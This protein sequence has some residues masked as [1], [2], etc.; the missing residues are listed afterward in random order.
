MDE[1]KIFIISKGD[2]SVGIQPDMIEMKWNGC[3]K[4]MDSDS[5]ERVRKE[6]HELFTG[7]LDDSR[8]SVHFEDECSE[9]GHRLAAYLKGPKK[10][11]YK[12]CSYKYCEC[13]LRNL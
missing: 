12:P 6:L 10:G 9:C 11:K 7:Y 13:N 8:L 1:L 4:G 3:W 5:R 2:T